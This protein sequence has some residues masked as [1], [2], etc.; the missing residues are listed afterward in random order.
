[1]ENPLHLNAAQAIEAASKSEAPLCQLLIELLGPDGEVERALAPTQQIPLLRR[2]AAEASAHERYGA[3]SLER[4]VR[5][6]AGRA[7]EIG[8]PLVT[9]MILLGALAAMPGIPSIIL[10]LLGLDEHVILAFAGH[11]PALESQTGQP[12]R[13][14]LAGHVETYLQ[15]ELSPLESVRASGA[16]TRCGGIEIELTAIET[17]GRGLIC[18][19]RVAARDSSIREITVTA[20]DINKTPLLVTPIWVDGPDISKRGGS[21]ITPRPPGGVVDVEIHVSV[22]GGARCSARFPL[23][24]GSREG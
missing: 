18:L 7:Q 23:Q 4:T 12:L 24:T 10:Q 1:M 9:P 14:G 5:H 6:A 15:V 3:T 19:W 20:L 11:V 13:D 8:A 2:L 22:D 21:A 16:S 17:R